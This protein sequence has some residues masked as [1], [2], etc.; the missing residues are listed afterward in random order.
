MQIPSI[1]RGK[2]RQAQ[3]QCRKTAKQIVRGKSFDEV[4]NGSMFDTVNTSGLLVLSR[5]GSSLDSFGENFYCYLLLDE[6][7]ELTFSLNMQGK[8]I[9]NALAI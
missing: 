5:C 4:I 1:F 2:Y 8:R 7:R 9:S 3:L 6:I